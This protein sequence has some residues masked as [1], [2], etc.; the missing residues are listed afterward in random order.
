M[1][2]TGPLALFY[3]FLRTFCAESST[4]K[5]SGSQEEEEGEGEEQERNGDQDEK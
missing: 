2:R 5:V 3:V 1:G 4:D